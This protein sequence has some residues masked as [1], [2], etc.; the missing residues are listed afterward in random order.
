MRSQLRPLFGWLESG[1]ESC[2]PAGAQTLFG[3]RQLLPRLDHTHVSLKA[4]FQCLQTFRIL[5]ISLRTLAS[6]FWQSKNVKETYFGSQIDGMYRCCYWCWRSWSFA[7]LDCS[8]SLCSSGS[9][10]ASE[11]SPVWV[12]MWCRDVWS[13]ESLA[14]SHLFF[15]A[16][17]K[18]ITAD[19][20][21]SL[22]QTISNIIWMWGNTMYNIYIIY[23]YN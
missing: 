19:L 3:H 10:C 5:Q 23:N 7:R 20:R 16:Q 12:A 15:C 18:Q 2:F 17:L 14:M 8:A 4:C 11:E 1:L 6:K 13:V 21:L 9:Q 22:F